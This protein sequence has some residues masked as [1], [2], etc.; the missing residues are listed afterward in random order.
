MAFPPWGPA[1]TR[2]DSPTWLSIL[3]SG[4]HAGMVPTVLFSEQPLSPRD[5]DGTQAVRGLPM[6]SVTR[7][8]ASP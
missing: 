7:Q 5:E 2:A 6:P 3:S 4:E 1:A 8:P